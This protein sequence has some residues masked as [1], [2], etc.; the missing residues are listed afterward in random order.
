MAISVIVSDV[1][2]SISISLYLGECLRIS[3]LI[4][5]ICLIGFF[6]E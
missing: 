2:F 1:L 6:N 3:C 5:G 4:L